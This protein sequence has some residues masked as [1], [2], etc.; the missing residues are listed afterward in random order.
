MDDGTGIRRS[1]GDGLGNTLLT[2]PHHAFRTA[3]EFSIV[4]EFRLT[5]I[6]CVVRGVFGG[7]MLF[8]GFVC[9]CCVCCVCC[10]CLCMRP[11]VRGRGFVQ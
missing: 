8:A 11:P 4:A 10:W 5:V 3:G 6:R 7:G 1:H 2:H 9:D